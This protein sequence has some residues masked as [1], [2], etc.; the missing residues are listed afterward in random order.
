MCYIG[1]MGFLAHLTRQRHAYNERL[2]ESGLHK[3]LSAFSMSLSDGMDDV[4]RCHVKGTVLDAGAGDLNGRRLLAPY[5]SKYV[6]IDI[7]R[8]SPELDYLG[9]V[10]DMKQFADES[11]DTV[12]TSQV[13][14][15]VAEPWRALGE[16]HRVLRPGG[17][18]IVQVPFLGGLHEEPYDFFRYTP[19]GLRS[20]LESA[21]FTIAAERRQGGLFAFITHPFSYVLVLSLWNVPLVRWI[22]WA[23]NLVALALPARVL[24]AV[25]NT[26][27]KYPGNVLMVA[28]KAQAP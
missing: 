18:L 17:R 21:K 28:S 23:A 6:S 16:F 9:D 3:Y 22:F 13:L 20:L 1:T 27:R 26:S 24:D 11:F 25:L 5:C 4:L 2:L 14:E 7:E 15:H 10:R 19:F 8:R 12:Y